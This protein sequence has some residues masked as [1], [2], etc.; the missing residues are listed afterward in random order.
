[1][2]SSDQLASEL[3]T[4]FPQTY[5]GLMA[6]ELDKKQQGGNNVSAFLQKVA[7]TPA[8]LK[9]G[10]R[11]RLVFALDA[12]GSREP[13]WDQ[14]MHTQAEMFAV[15]QD[16]GGLDVQLCFFRGFGEF[17]AS[18][19]VSDPESLLHS[20]TGVR[21]LGGRTQI[22]R[23][24]RHGLRLTGEQKVNAIVFVGDC[25]EESVDTLCHLAGQFGLKGTPLF[26]FQEGYDPVAG[27]AFRQMAKL[28]GGAWC[29][30]DAGSVDQLRELLSAVA[31]FAA[32][33][34]KALAD[35]SGKGGKEAV[36]L[37]SNQMTGRG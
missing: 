32:G 1:M 9:A 16:I 3:D 34:R 4:G 18:N 6:T 2:I 24:L 36:R 30:F 20:M 17:K 7:R 35:L 33:G 15:T 31:A 29:Q 13:T 19:W 22:E 8:P 28:S 27:T 12:T 10:K 26:L 5:V 11:G 25:M 37:I 23:V 14:A 21:C